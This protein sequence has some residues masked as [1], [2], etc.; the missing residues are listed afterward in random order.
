[1]GQQK[2]AYLFEST[3]RERRSRM[4]IDFREALVG[5]HKKEYE[6]APFL[7]ESAW[8]ERGQDQNRIKKECEC[9]S[10]DTNSV[11]FLRSH[12]PTGTLI[13]WH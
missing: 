9:E 8:R 13:L 1:V 12:V 4:R 5:Q 2:G 11:F 10:D 3:W 6:S 7:F